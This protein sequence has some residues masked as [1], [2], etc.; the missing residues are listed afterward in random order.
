FQTGLALALVLALAHL[1]G[2]ATRTHGARPVRGRRLAPLIAAVLVLPGLAWPYLNGAILQPGSFQELPRYWHTT[3]DWLE[4]YSPDSRALVVPATAHG[5]YTWGSPI[6]EPLDVLAD[7]RWAER[8]YV[9]FGSVAFVHLT[10][11]RQLIEDRMSHRKGHFM[12]SALSRFAANTIS[13]IATISVTRPTGMV[14]MP[15]TMANE[16]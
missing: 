8:D 4:K 6:D 12:Y 1:V 5:I 16:P 3:A 7:S 11:D 10:G 9:P 14:K 13:R 2:V 15:L